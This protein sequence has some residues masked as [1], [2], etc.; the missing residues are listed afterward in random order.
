MYAVSTCM[1]SLQLNP[2]CQM[3]E[4]AAIAR[5]M[6][7]ASNGG[8]ADSHGGARATHGINPKLMETIVASNGE[9]P[10]GYQAYPDENQKGRVGKK[11]NKNR[12]G[13]GGE[14]N[15]E[16]R[17][18]SSDAHQY[19]G[20]FDSA[21]TERL[22]GSTYVSTN[23]SADATVGTA[24]SNITW[25]SGSA[26]AASGGGSSV[27]GQQELQQPR[28]FDCA[29][30]AAVRSAAEQAAFDKLPRRWRYNGP[31]GESAVDRLG[32]YERRSFQSD[33]VSTISTFDLQHSALATSFEAVRRRFQAAERKTK[34]WRRIRIKLISVGV[35]RRLHRDL[36]GS[37]W[38]HT[39]LDV[40]LVDEVVSFFRGPPEYTLLM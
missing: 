1:L 14:R 28:D 12:R 16:G 6:H 34:Q 13:T 33:S 5:M 26:S 3:D 31:S 20:S 23:T 36:L 37:K 15:P 17:Q 38:L 2:T 10:R 32:R 25:W 7:M 39:K 8:A 27:P 22:S 4:E 35:F 11:R 18:S 29:D 30:A 40:V 24:M 21:R 9:M 19:H